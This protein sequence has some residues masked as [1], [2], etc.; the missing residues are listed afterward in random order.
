MVSIERLLAKGVIKLEDL[1]SLI[2][3]LVYA[4]VDA[5]RVLRVRDL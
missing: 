3:P 2:N 1:T 4:R 5:G